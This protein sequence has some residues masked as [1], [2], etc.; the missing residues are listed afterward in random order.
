MAADPYKYFRVEAREL[1]EGLGKGL[2]ELEKGVSASDIVPRLL[3]LA[4]TLKGAARVVK[5]RDIADLSHAIED[6]LVPVRDGTGAVTH[7]SIDSVFRLVDSITERVVALGAPEGT[8]ASDSPRASV[9]EPA[10]A[11]RADVEQVNALIDGI[12]EASSQVAL[13]RRSAGFLARAQKL[14]E[15]LAD[16]LAS[17]APDGPHGAT[18]KLRAPADELRSLLDSLA[19]DLVLGVEQLERELRQVAGAAEQ[20]RLVPAAM[21]FNAL[22]RAARDAGSSLGKRFAFETR[23]GDVRLDGD[24]LARVQS[25]LVQA[26]RNSVAHGIEPDAERKAA[27]KPPE[28]RISVEV[29]RKDG[30]VSF[31]CR[32]D[33]RGVDLEAVRRAAERRGMLTSEAR[34]LGPEELLRLLLR[35]GISTSGSVTTV[36]GRGIGLDVVRETAREL[37]GEATVRTEGRRGTVLEILVP[38]SRSALDALL[39]EAEGQVAAIPLDAVRRTLRVAPE[40]VT[41]S[42]EGESIVVEGKVLPFAP[43][44]QSLRLGSVSRS[45][46]RAWSAVLVQSRGALAA[47][48]V[49]RL[50]GTENVVA[51]ALP[52]G[53]AADPIVSGATLDPEGNPRMVLAPDELVAAARRAREAKSSP[54]AERAPI[55][56]IDDSLTTRMLEQSILESA[57][58]EVDLA[59]SGEDGLERAKKRPYAL[60]L[61]DVE[62]PG[63]DGFTFIERSRNDP[64]LR[65]IPA[66]L[67]T[68]RASPEDRRRGEVAGARGYIMKGDFDQTEL[69]RKIKELV[70]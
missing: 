27:K 14:A 61:V 52:E 60:F 64:G 68:S 19:R 21:M 69:L 24:V 28:G 45:S 4:H 29:A 63:M 6:A 30:R 62:M 23:G 56:V 50:L 51:R 57:G 7:E 36:S 11:L 13:V 46:G 44:A 54:H 32:D 58:Y 16:R 70:G 10:R 42:A 9:E 39:V 55:L 2:L 49:D 22:E 48:G 33:G 12:A 40:E 53:M 35:G 59:I 15:V 26:V 43:L 47:V 41:R 20:L 65:D 66:I 38:V 8:D 67:V 5:Q 31:V 1:L 18:L 3:R 17:R 25:A 34:S 37:G